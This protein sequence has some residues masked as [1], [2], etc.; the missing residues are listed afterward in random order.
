[1]ARADD[2]LPA[3][4]VASFGSTILDPLEEYDGVAER[5]AEAFPGHDVAQ[6]YLSRD[7]VDHWHF[8][9][10]DMIEKKERVDGSRFMGEPVSFWDDDFD[11]HT[12]HYAGIKSPLSVL[13]KMHQDRQPVIVQP[14]LVADGEIYRNLALLVNALGDQPTIK[15][16]DRPFPWIRLGPPA[17]GLGDGAD[18]ARLDRAALALSELVEEARDKKAALVLVARGNANLKQEVFGR[19]E[20]RLRRDWPHVYVGTLEAGPDSEAVAEA[21]AGNP[22]PSKKRIVLAPLMAGAGNLAFDRVLGPQIKG[23][24]PNDSWRTRLEAKG[25]KVDQHHRGLAGIDSW[26]DLYVES[27][28][29]VKD[30]TLAELEERSKRAPKA[31]TAS[32]G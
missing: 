6:A 15:E 13:A 3:I 22:P 14:L 26:A 4:C 31:G 16:R 27:V 9:A 24:K 11:P 19:F 12:I 25:F 18:A 8:E 1:M 2:D 20:A 23:F 7:V 5:I 29:E 28:R 21:L 30:K 32:R 10:E 17:L